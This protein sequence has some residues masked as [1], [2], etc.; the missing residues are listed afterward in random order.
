VEYPHDYATTTP[1]YVAANMAK[2]IPVG[3]TGNS[4]ADIIQS[5]LNAD[6]TVNASSDIAKAI[7][8]V[9]PPNTLTMYTD[10]A[11]PFDYA[12]QYL[13]GAPG[14]PGHARAGVTKGIIFETDGTPENGN[15]TCQQAQTAASAA[16]AANIE[17]FTIG[18][19]AGLPPL[20]HAGG[21]VPGDLC[22]DTS[23]TW[24]G[25][26]IIQSLAAMAT[27]SSST[28]TTACDANENTDNDHFYCSASAQSLKDAFRS[29]AAQLAAGSKLVQ[30]YPIPLITNV[31]PGTGPVAGGTTVAISGQFFTGAS[32]VTFGGAA[33][34]SFSVT[35][36]SSITAVAP[37]GLAGTV[38]ITVTTGGGVSPIVAAD[39][40]RYGP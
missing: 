3:L 13:A 7:G 26:T 40:Y 32:K 9:R 2:W 30:L 24:R 35:S 16:K 11:S 1:A 4:N 12:K 31:G 22:P 39:H 19:F 14:F 10:Q 27:N 28:S 20:R 34:S 25:R 29:A 23:G 5:Y 37:A 15:F 18:F 17:V 6:G 8:C 21:H 33:A 36:D 38:D